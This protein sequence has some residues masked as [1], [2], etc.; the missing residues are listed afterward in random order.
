MD[1]AVFSDIH[2]N[3]AALQACID[4]CMGKGITNY[5][6][7]GDFISDCPGVKKTMELIYVLKQYFTCYIIR[8]NREEYMLNNRKNGENLWEK[9]SGSGSLLYT[10]SGVLRECRD[11]SIAMDHQL[12]R[13][14]F[15]LVKRG[16]PSVL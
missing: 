8:G 16:T 7:L 1:I 5:I 10:A 6:L 12:C 13:Q 2:G 14:S 3:D 4:Y 9:G 15:C 11:L